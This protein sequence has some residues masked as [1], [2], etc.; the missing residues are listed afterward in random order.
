MPLYSYTAKRS[1]GRN[2]RG[3]L[4]AISELEVVE[5]LHQRSLTV[6]D[7]LEKKRTPEKE[8]RRRLTM[9]TSLFGSGV[10][11]DEV[12]LFASQMSA[13]VESGLPLLRC[14]TSFGNEVEN[15]QF[16]RVIDTVS[17]DVE[18]GSTFFDALSKHP[19]VFNRLF[20]NM[21]KAGE[22]SG[23]LDQTLAQLANYLERSANLRRK[24][25]AAITYP[26]FLIGFTVFAIIILVVKVVPVFQ[27][28][29]AGAKVSLPAPTQV[30]I[31]SSVAIRDYYWLLLLVA[32]AVGLFIYF[33]LQTERGRFF[34]DKNNLRIPILG[35]LMRKY[36]LTK[37]TRTLGVLINS[38]VP[39][40]AAM[41]LVAETSDNKV[42]EIAVNESSTS[43]E[44]GSGFAEALGERRTVFP[45]MVIQ[46]SATGEESG[47]LDKM[48]SKVANFYEQ[49]I[50]ASITTL[51][52][53]IEPILVIFIGSVVGGI[54]LSIFL[55]IFKMGRAFR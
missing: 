22:I 46:M 48:L 19:K 20:I 47:T 49:Q 1:D 25:K 38:G 4:E 3:D 17:I 26:L 42:L 53:L 10:K 15:P 24:V 55:P 5:T 32:A 33:Q 23:K 52:N 36:S 41:D 2:V 37:F 8:L 7:I 29:Y 13:M 12:L 51:T 39:I 27:K 14:L 35:Q 21:V 31:A 44:Q 11:H 6:L 9:R 34:W 54:L 50:E 45:E 18:E 30:L 16:K 40:L 43:I 28:I